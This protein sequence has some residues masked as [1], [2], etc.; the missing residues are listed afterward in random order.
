MKPHV[1]VT[2]RIPPVGLAMLAEVADV[3]L[4]RGEG[5][6]PRAELLA[7][8]RDKDAIL[9]LLTDR[10]DADVMDAAPGLRVI[11]NHA[12][13]YDNIDVAEATRRG[14]AVTNTPAC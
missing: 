11:A 13:G 3:D 1:L 14:I 9:S 10:I 5:A 2:R 8:V 12:V 6:I 7:R 4:Y